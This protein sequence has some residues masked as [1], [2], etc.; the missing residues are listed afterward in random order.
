MAEHRFTG[1]RM[2][3]LGQSR[4]HASALTRSENDDIERHEMIPDEQA[5]AVAGL[6]IQAKE[7]KKEKG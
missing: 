7:P 6:T 4:T 2:Q 1:H 3:D 5:A